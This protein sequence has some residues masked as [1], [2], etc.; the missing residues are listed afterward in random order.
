[1][2]QPS[3][4]VGLEKLDRVGFDIG[5]CLLTIQL[6]LNETLLLQGIMN[7]PNRT[8]LDLRLDL[9]CAVRGPAQAE[10]FVRPVEPQ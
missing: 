4:R 10:F 1:M 7:S 5:L 2:T 9:G 3:D 8:R 6:N